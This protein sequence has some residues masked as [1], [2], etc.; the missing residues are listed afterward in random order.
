MNEPTLD[1]HESIKALQ[2][3]FI[4]LLPKIE[5]TVR[6][7]LQHIS[8][9][10]RQSDLVC[11][12]IAMCWKWYIGLS[13]KG[14][15]RAEFLY[16]FAALAAR[17]AHS[18]RRLCGSEKARDALSP[19]CQ[20]MRNFTVSPLPVTSGMTAKVFDDALIDNT[21]TPVPDQVQFRLDFPRWRASLGERSRILMDAMIE[22]HR[23]NELAAVFR[24]TQARISQ[25]RRE[26]QEGWH[27]FCG[28]NDPEETQRV[29]AA[30]GCNRQPA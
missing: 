10:D 19:R 15:S 7:H 27:S 9:S 4:T 12:A 1:Q 24:V 6:V 21:Q 17:A 28:D 30:F 5:Y 20:R 14:R 25:V 26:L 13:R 2:A 23:T 3:E 8:C 16:T 22:G 11:E 29:E 18:G